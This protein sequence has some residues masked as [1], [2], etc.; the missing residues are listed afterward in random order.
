MRGNDEKKAL[1]KR[2]FSSGK[3]NVHLRGP[4][5]SVL[6]EKHSVRALGLVRSFE[7]NERL[8]RYFVQLHNPAQHLTLLRVKFP[9]QTIQSQ[10]SQ[11]IKR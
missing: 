4:C 9:S 7:S 10:R 11:E 2:K 3:N 1:I 6:K 8:P 5:V